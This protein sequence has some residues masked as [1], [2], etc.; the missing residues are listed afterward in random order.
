M[1]QDKM[2]EACPEVFTVAQSA[3][4]LRFEFKPQFDALIQDAVKIVDTLTIHNRLPCV[5]EW[6]GLSGAPTFKRS[7]RDRRLKPVGGVTKFKRKAGVLEEFKRLARKHGR[8]YECGAKPEG[9]L[10]DHKAVCSG[11]E[12][13]FRR[14]MGIVKAMVEK[15]KGAEVNSPPPKKD[16]K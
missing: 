6:A 7:N 16:T 4:N 11:C 14:R 12:N 15:G 3:F 5:Q 10:A 2:L 1:L 8:C 9:T 13:D